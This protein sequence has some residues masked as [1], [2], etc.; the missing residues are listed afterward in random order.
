MMAGQKALLIFLFISV[1]VLFTLSP[2]HALPQEDE[3]EKPSADDIYKELTKLYK[4]KRNL[5]VETIAAL[6]Q[7]IDESYKEADKSSKGKMAKGVK[8][9]FDISNPDPNLLKTAVGTLVCMGKN[10]K[11]ALWWALNHKNLKVRN[12]KDKEEARNKTAIKA[13]IIEGIGF[14]GEKSSIKKLTDLLWDDDMNIVVATCKALSQYSKIPLKER[15]PIVKELV[16]R[17]VNINSISVANPK[18]DDY[19]QNLLQV[20]VPFNEAL[21][22]LTLKSLEDAVAWEKWYNDNKGKPKW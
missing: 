2:S 10:G 16:K 19:R 4:N 7:I 12:K 9:V 11:D 18:R 1:S 6:F 5:D 20:E 22:A 3:A 13:F 14:N 21:R 8:K 17:Y 15:K